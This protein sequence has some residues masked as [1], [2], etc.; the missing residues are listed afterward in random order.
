MVLYCMCMVLQGRR[1]DWTH[2]TESGSD[3]VLPNVLDVAGTQYRTYANYEHA[4]RWF[5]DAPTEAVHAVS[6]LVLCRL[7]SSAP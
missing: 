6:L 2:Y 3:E 4:W 7:P 5:L 1:H